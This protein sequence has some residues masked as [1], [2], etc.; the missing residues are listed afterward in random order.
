MFVTNSLENSSFNTQHFLKFVNQKTSP[1][2][3]QQPFS[4]FSPSTTKVHHA[5]N[6][7]N[8]LNTQEAAGSLNKMACISF[9]LFYMHTFY[10]L[11]QILGCLI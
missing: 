7:A 2:S 6:Y 3:L 9:Y 11:C 4:L 8:I 10:V 1:L 5:I